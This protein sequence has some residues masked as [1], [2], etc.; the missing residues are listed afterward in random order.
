MT[1]EKSDESLILEYADEGKKDSLGELVRRHWAQAYRISLR[2]LGDAAAAEDAAQEAFMALVRKGS[3]FDRARSFGPWFRTIVMNAARDASRSRKTRLRH[4]A[5]AQETRPTSVAHA[6]ETRIDET[7]VARSLEALPFDV[8]FPLVLHFYEG[9]SYDEVAATVGC[10][11]STAQS[12]IGRGIADLRESLVAAG[13]GCTVPGLE[14]FFTE[15][16]GKAPPVPGAPTVAMIEAGAKVTALSVLALKALPFVLALGLGAGLAW[17]AAGGETREP[18]PRETA[19]AAE[20]PL[21]ADGPKDAAPASV[22]TQARSGESELPLV[23]LTPPGAA[24]APVALVTSA[25]IPEQTVTLVVLDRAGS[26]VGSATVAIVSAKVWQ[27]GNALP[28]DLCYPQGQDKEKTDDAGRVSVPVSGSGSLVFL[29]RKGS[30]CG[31]LGPVKIDAGYQGV[32]T[33]LEPHEP[34]AGRGTLVATVH[35]DRRLLANDGL[36]VEMTGGNPRLD[37]SFAPKSTDALGRAVFRDVLP[38]TYHLVLSK[39]D[40]SPGTVDVVIESGEITS[41]DVDL[42]VPTILTGRLTLPHGSRPED[43]SVGM[44]DRSALLDDDAPSVANGSYSVT[45]IGPGKHTLVAKLGGFADFK[46]DVTIEHAG[47]AIGPEITF[48]EHPVLSGRVVSQT[49]EPVAAVEVAIR[50]VDGRVGEVSAGADGTFALRGLAPGRYE[51]GFTLETA[52]A[53][54]SVLASREV[55]MTAEDL[56]LGDVKVIVPSAGLAVS[57]KV[58]DR[59]GNP[60]AGAEVLFSNFGRAPEPVTSGSD[61]TFAIASLD[62][63]TVE[64]AARKG[65]LTSPELVIEEGQSRSAIV[66]TLSERA[67]SISGTVHGP[68]GLLA[69]GVLVR[70]DSGSNALSVR[71]RV[72]VGKDGS[73]VATGLPPGHYFVSVPSATSRPGSPIEELST[74]V[75]PGADEHLDLT[76]GGESIEVSVTGAPQRTFSRVSAHW[77]AAPRDLERS[78]REELDGD[79]KATLVYV[80]AG[81]ATVEVT[82]SPPGSHALFAFTRE[83]EVVTGTPAKVEVAFPGAQAGGAIEGRAVIGAVDPQAFSILAFGSG[84]TVTARVQEGGTFHLDSLPPGRYRVLAS[85]CHDPDPTQGVEVEVTRGGVATVAAAPLVEQP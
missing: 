16:R 20:A 15:A 68:P 8:R 49:G 60:V 48:A 77:K 35:A 71:A 84:L 41:S 64:L 43:V 67:G 59:S 62:A 2:V 81:Q 28:W 45:G 22:D 26:P 29:A 31:I 57:G 3:R 25:A 79:G 54:T 37:C 19:K 83:V 76:L 85:S 5:R 21:A 61:G 70:I 46:A 50:R 27:Q 73:F 18:P 74:D 63:A 4:E 58:V 55:V 36:G 30:A 1:S 69:N 56:S 40:R 44:V 82:L 32:I 80:P 42:G 13:C 12:R 75:R 24:R 53:H 33:L 10:P 38:G 78:P 72:T 65:D 9:L 23:R 6:G 51:V 39:T 7:E 47:P 34:A 66:L 14:T 17:H 52:P 11:K